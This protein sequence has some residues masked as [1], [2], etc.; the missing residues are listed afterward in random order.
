MTK[1]QLRELYLD[2]LRREVAYQDRVR[3]RIRKVNAV[4]SKIEATINNPVNIEAYDNVWVWSD[5]H[6]G[7]ANV[8]QYCK[9]PFTSV[10]EMT[11]VMVENHNKVVGPDDLVIWVGDVAF[12]NEERTDAILKRLNGDRILVIGNHDI[13][14]KRVKQ[15]DFKEQH[16][17]YTIEDS[18]MPLLFT[19]FS[20]SNIPTPW[21]NV[22]GHSH[23]KPHDLQDSPHHFNVSVEVINYTP[24][25]IDEIKKIAKSQLDQEL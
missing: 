13:H 19:H 16:L 14:K 2:D 9:R 10:Q 5:T 7:H 3:P 12:Y 22:H 24:I 20:M 11:Y 18:A 4:W 15:L 1:D 6:F 17:L 23:N 21:F 8:I 25:H